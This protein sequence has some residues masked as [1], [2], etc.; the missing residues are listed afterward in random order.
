MSRVCREVVRPKGPSVSPICRWPRHFSSLAHARA[1]AHANSTAGPK[2]EGHGCPQSRKVTKR[3]FALVVCVSPS[4]SAPG[5]VGFAHLSIADSVPGCESLFFACSRTR[6]S[7]C[8][9][10]SWPERRRA[11]MPGAK[12]SNQ[13]DLRS[14]CLC[15]A[16]LFGPRSR[17]FRP[18]VDRRLSGRLRVT[19]LCMLAHAQ[20]RVRTAQP[21]RKA[22]GM[23]AR[24]QEK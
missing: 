7:A 4:C 12:K 5:V 8:E 11:W 2:G 22:K 13:E 1:G 10:H 16:K 14:G 21:A 23:D 6:R 15:L 9:Q 18:S 17:R 19:F 20:E 3:T 24:S